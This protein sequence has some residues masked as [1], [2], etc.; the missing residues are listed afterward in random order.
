MLMIAPQGLEI[1]EKLL[2]KYELTRLFVF[3][4]WFRNLDKKEAYSFYELQ[5]EYQ[6][7]QII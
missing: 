4:S 2:W 1:G 6:R 3:F 5:E 7:I